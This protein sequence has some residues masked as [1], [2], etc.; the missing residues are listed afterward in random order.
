MDSPDILPI[1]WIGVYELYN[2]RFIFTWTIEFLE[3][4]SAS[5][6]WNLQTLHA[7][8]CTRSVIW[9]MPLVRHLELNSFF[10]PD[11]PDARI[12]L[13]KLHTLSTENITVQ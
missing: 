12:V 6:Y 8:K 3:S 10:L 4:L 5:L 1:Y 2:L 7:V 11:P 9:T 13:T